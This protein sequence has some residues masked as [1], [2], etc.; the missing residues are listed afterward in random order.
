MPVGESA[1]IQPLWRRVFPLSGQR[2]RH[3]LR[4]RPLS[5]PLVTEKTRH[6]NT[7]TGL[8]LAIENDPRRRTFLELPE[9]ALAQREAAELVE[10]QRDDVSL[11][12]FCLPPLH[13]VA[14]QVQEDLLLLQENDEGA[15]ILTSGALHFPS[16]WSL[17]DKLGQE[18]LQIHSPVSGFA[19]TE[20]AI[21]SREFLGRL[22]PGHPVWRSNWTLQAGDGLDLSSETRDDWIKHRGRIEDANC[23]DFVHL[24]IE[25]QKLFRLRKSCAILF[26]IHTVLASLRE[27]AS[28]EPEN[29]YLLQT[30]ENLDPAVQ[31]YKGLTEYLP[32]V[33]R[34]LRSHC[35]TAPD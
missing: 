15:L 31:S 33:L 22:R 30:L 24:R 7:E 9:A 18:F 20:V 21:R 12:A 3:A 19:Q 13:S 29:L 8:K 28:A 32:V 4:V 1:S 27:V 2:Y 35:V 10:Q 14:L 25:Y 34:G 5:P 16:A 6:H 23:L 26:S 17:V 11:E